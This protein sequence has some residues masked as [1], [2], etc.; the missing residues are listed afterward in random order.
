MR[1]G[2]VWD[3]RNSM[4]TRRD[5]KSTQFTSCASKQVQVLRDFFF[6]RRKETCFMGK[7]TKERH[8]NVVCSLFEY[9]VNTTLMIDT[10]YYYDPVKFLL[11]PPP[12]KIVW[13]LFLSHSIRYT[14]RYKTISNVSSGLDLNFFIGKSWW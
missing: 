1:S 10:Y 14:E 3:C 9:F 5:K 8:T 11:S 2:R 13:F 12:S 6:V 4:H 7:K